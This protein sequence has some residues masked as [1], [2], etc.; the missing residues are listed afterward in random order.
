MRGHVF[1][2]LSGL[3]LVACGSY[4]AAGD[5][6]VICNASVSLPAQEIRDVYFGDK[7]FAGSVKLA[8]ADN[9]AAQVDF[10]AKVMKLDAN[11]YT[12]LWIKKAFRDGSTP[13]PVK[14]SDAEAI[15]YVEQ[16]IGACSYVAFAPGTGV[17]VVAKF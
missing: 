1:G 4:A 3:S 13:P 10:L 17:V 14:A 12:S 8:P 9:S 7:F 11:K 15:A 16:T 6:F 2:L 5:I